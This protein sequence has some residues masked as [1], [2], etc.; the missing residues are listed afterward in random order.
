MNA[1]KRYWIKTF[2]FLAA[3]ILLFLSVFAFDGVRATFQKNNTAKEKHETVT[4]VIAE[5]VSTWQKRQIPNV[6]ASA[7]AS[8]VTR[9]AAIVDFD[10]VFLNDNDDNHLNIAPVESGTKDIVMEPIAEPKTESEIKP[11]HVSVSNN[12]PIDTVEEDYIVKAQ[13][14][15]ESATYL[16][17][18][19]YGK[20]IY[21]DDTDVIYLCKTGWGEADIVKS[22]MRR[23]AVL[24]VILDRVN[25]GQGTIIEVITAPSQ[26]SGYVSSNPVNE[27]WE[28]LV[29]DV[30]SRWSMEKDGYEDVGR[31]IPEDY[32][33]F[34]GDG[35]ENHF[36]NAYSGNY[37]IWNW[38]LPNPYES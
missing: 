4:E 14:V 11:E 28:L 2:A 16:L 38:S 37:T 25:N 26:F 1:R 21:W 36:R 35:R 5:T 20:G 19:D 13:L 9:T 27:D 32:L 31:I 17:I 15:S 34:R 24:W 23:A 18:P 7:T 10:E 3:S 29:R 22:T 33:W 30:L 6:Y 8:H 12:A